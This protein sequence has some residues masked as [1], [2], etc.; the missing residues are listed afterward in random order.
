MRVGV[1]VE[2][3]VE[4]PRSVRVRVD[5]D[6]AVRTWDYF[7]LFFVFVY[8]IGNNKNIVAYGLGSVSL[9]STFSFT[10]FFYFGLCHFGP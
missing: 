7:L 4:L 9:H 5:H 6:A 2:Q 1:L 10:F 8:N 3:R